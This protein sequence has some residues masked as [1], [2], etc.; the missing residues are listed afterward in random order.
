M[1]RLLP[2]FETYQEETEAVRSF[3]DP[4]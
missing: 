1:A 4:S 3:T 2:T